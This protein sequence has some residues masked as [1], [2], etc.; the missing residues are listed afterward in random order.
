MDSIYPKAMIIIKDIFN[1]GI[2]NLRY[3]KNT[4]VIKYKLFQKRK[5][6]GEN[7]SLHKSIYN[8]VNNKLKSTKLFKNIE[9]K[10]LSFFINKS[11]I[12]DKKNI[13]LKI[14]SKKTTTKILGITGFIIF[15]FC[16]SN[17]L[18][19]ESIKVNYLSMSKENE[20]TISNI[21]KSPKT[22][23]TIQTKYNEETQNVEYSF[24]VIDTLDSYY[25][26]I[27]LDEPSTFLKGELLKN[28]EQKTVDINSLNKINI[29][30]IVDYKDL[31]L[32]NN[33]Y[34]INKEL[35]SSN[36]IKSIEKNIEEKSSYIH[37][38]TKNITITILTI[39]LF[40]ILNLIYLSSKKVISNY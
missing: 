22:N 15:S 30:S 19:K 35:I 2:T 27:K 20:L 7:I 13:N 29:N 8:I 12:K 11:N 16:T 6:N 32:I 14:I 26:K 38:H 21:L 5:Q 18:F 10:S 9:T 25:Y 40:T 37:N 1:K 31:Y 34:K 3:L 4:Y 39:S 33:K 17:V 24:M 36:D 28:I 23:T